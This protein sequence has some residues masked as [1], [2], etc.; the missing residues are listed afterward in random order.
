MRSVKIALIDSGVDINHP[1]LR[2][3]DIKT[4]KYNPKKST[5]ENT[6]S[7]CQ[8]HG[9]A[10]AHIILRQC[11]DVEIL[12]IK[13]LNEK[14]G[15]SKNDLVN[16]L[17]WLY[18]Q[19][20]NI[21]NLSLGTRI[22]AFENELNEVCHHLAAQGKYIVSAFSNE[23]DI[24]YPA[25]LREVIGV[26]GID[27]YDKSIFVYDQK[28]NNVYIKQNFYNVCTKDNQ[29]KDVSGNSFA[30]GNFTGILAKMINENSTLMEK[31]IM[32]HLIDK[33][34]SFE[35]IDVINRKRNDLSWMKRTLLF[36]LS[37]T[38]LDMVKYLRLPYEI[39]GF[40]E[41]KNT[42]FNYYTIMKDK[43]EFKIRL[44]KTLEDGLIN[45]DTLL[46]GDI[47]YVDKQKESIIYELSKKT[48]QLNKNIFC[49]SGLSD[50]HYYKLSQLAKEKGVRLY[51]KEL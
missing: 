42:L 28:D 21:I 19:D 36:P 14:L 39:A 10:I 37:Q 20:V 7:D 4:I 11:V 41:P 15:A 17:K 2:S 23:S 3:A 32:H 47:L 50:S 40:Y 49:K 12:S 34:S 38:M 6:I 1:Q 43:K 25:R 33:S 45:A 29:Y 26:K 13:L 22:H 31:E 18:Y 8:G 16:V 44:F 24:S 51:S 5:F 9:S 48:L 46:I 27:F 35:E 30:A